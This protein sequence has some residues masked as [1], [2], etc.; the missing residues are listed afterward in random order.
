MGGSAQEIL[1]RPGNMDGIPKP[2]RFRKGS[3]NTYQYEDPTILTF[4]LMFDWNGSHSPL[5]N[6]AAERFLREVCGEV[7]RADELK[8]FIKC[9]KEIN[10]KMPWTFTQI[11][12]VGAAMKYEH[13]KEAYRGTDDGLTITMTETMDLSM[14]GLF[15]MYHN[16]A[17]DNKRWVEVLPHNLTY[18]TMYVCV[19]EARVI[20]SYKDDTT[21]NKHNDFE[22]QNQKRDYTQVNMD[23]TG[24][25]KP[26][27]MLQYEKCTF[28][29]D[30]LSEAFNTLSAKEPASLEEISIGV[31]YHKV[32][33]YSKQ[34]LN[35]LLGERIHDADSGNVGNRVSGAVGKPK[36]AA[37]ISLNDPQVSGDPNNESQSPSDKTTVGHSSNNTLDPPPGYP[38]RI[39]AKFP[40]LPADGVENRI[41]DK[42]KDKAETFKPEN[43]LEDAAKKLVGMGK[44]LIQDQ[45]GALFLGNVYGLNA[46]STIQDAFNAGGLNGLMMIGQ[47]AADAI[48]NETG[49]GANL[50]LGNILPDA[51]P[52]ITLSAENIIPEV[53]GETNLSAE[54]MRPPVR[55]EQNLTSENIFGNIPSETTLSSTNIFPDTEVE[56]ALSPENIFPGPGALEAPLE[57]ANVY[58]ILPLEPPLEPGLKAWES[59]EPEEDSDLGSI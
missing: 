33:F 41:L 18:F 16:I 20:Q 24:G 10:I 46:M 55:P 56:Q 15:D 59:P 1:Q 52:E 4:F 50:S 34:Y 47:T 40:G 11:E 57:S 6:G 35:G 37:K 39:G 9:L 26:H 14:M 19:E 32:E 36:D 17:F 58:P 22:P 42:L 54:N 43:I 5:F 3:Y 12:G 28:N 31:K 53:P 29:V 8:R 25:M 51:Q 30:P 48:Q 38:G 13:M 49:G 23:I 7:K 21:I 44:G 27:F 45:L 2:M